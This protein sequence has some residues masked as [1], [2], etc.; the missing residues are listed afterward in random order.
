VCKG[1]WC[2]NLR[3]RDNLKVPGIGER[4]I[5]RW[6]IR[7]W[8]VGAWTGSSWLRIGTVEGALMNAVMNI[9]DP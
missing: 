8:D 7:K 1:F 2:G 6:V 4:I 5:L 9:R 3:Q